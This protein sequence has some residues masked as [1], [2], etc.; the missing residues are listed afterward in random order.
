MPL[1]RGSRWVIAY[2][3]KVFT[4][5]HMFFFAC[6]TCCGCGYKST[7]SNRKKSP[8]VF[9]KI[10][11]E[12]MSL[13]YHTIKRIMKDCSKIVCLRFT[14]WGSIH[15][16]TQM[17]WRPTMCMQCT[18]CILTSDICPGCYPALF[19]PFPQFLSIILPPV[20]MVYTL[21]SPATLYYL[22][23]CESILAAYESIRSFL[24][25]IK[26]RLSVCSLLAGTMCSRSRNLNLRCL[27]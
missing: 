23:D 20:L 21:E 12:I 9:F 22:Y 10:H 5:K 24:G 16:T 26:T 11:P 19:S 3:L 13:T 25:V 6:I 8:L 1:S 18:H 2:N 27:S 4:L 17:S 15:S 7:P 14:G